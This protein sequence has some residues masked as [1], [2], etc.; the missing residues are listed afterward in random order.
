M[1]KSISTEMNRTHLN[2]FF[3]A[4]M[5]P[6]FLL[7]SCKRD[8]DGF[9]TEKVSEIAGTWTATRASFNGVDVVEEGGAVTLVIQNNGKFTFTI[10]RPNRTDMVFTGKLGF[11]EQWLAVEYDSNPGEYEY[12]DITY[13][14]NHMHIGANSEFDFDGDG[15]DEVV[16]FFLDMVR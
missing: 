12:Y 16:I 5:V 15:T 14:V 13:D 11:D 3:V 4:V 6:V 8:E 2:L 9:S 7:I 10:A 1:K